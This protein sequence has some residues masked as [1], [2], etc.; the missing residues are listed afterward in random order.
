MYKYILCDLD[1]T[2]LDF[3]EGEETAI[4]HVFE[5]EG[6]T[7]SDELYARYHDINVGLWR[8]LEAGRVD[9]HHVLTYRFEIFFKTLGIDVDGAVKEQIFREHINN[10]HELVDG[11]L[12]F[13][14]YLKG[15]GYILCTATNGVFYTQMKRMKDAGILDYFSHHFISEEIGYEKPH[16]NFFKHCI[17]TLEVKDLSEVL[18]IGDT[19]T[20]DIIGAHQFGIDSC[21]YGVRQVDATYHIEELEEIKSIL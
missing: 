10:S 1:N 7:F 17:E 12:Q 6:V 4:K 9:K 20:S 13:L 2:I 3:K 18:M 21:Y 15:K 11:A 5:S 8:E 14:D 19:Y 16:H